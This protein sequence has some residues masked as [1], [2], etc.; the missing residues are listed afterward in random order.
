MC[1]GCSPCAKQNLGT[2]EGE[3]GFLAPRSIKSNF[4][5][6]EGMHHEFQKQLKTKIGQDFITQNIC[7]IETGSERVPGGLLE[8][9]VVLIEDGW[10]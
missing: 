1:R 5:I 8:W 7:S 4:V 6:F 9:D 10:D 3:G 2:Q